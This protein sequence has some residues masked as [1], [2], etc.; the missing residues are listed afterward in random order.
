METRSC[1]VHGW[2]FPEEE[3]NG[4]C[5]KCGQKVTLGRN[6]K[7]SK[8]KKNVVD[9]DQL[10]S[11]YGADTARLFSLFAA[12]PEKDL[13]WN[14]QGVEG[15]Y[16]FL[17]RVWRAVYDNFDLVSGAS[18]SGDSD[19]R[20]KALR[21]QT[22]RTIKKVTE[23]IDGSFHFNTAISAVME[24]VNAI[25]AF[26]AKEQC[27]GVV[28]EALE[29][30]VLLLAPFVPHFSEELWL[31]LGHVGGVE[32]AGWPDF[33]PA[34]LVEEEK[35]IVVQVNGK[36]RGKVTVAANADEETLRAAA[37]AEDNVVR[38]IEGKTVRKVIVVPGRLVNVVVS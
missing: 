26:D 36:V 5:S 2:L 24:L 4:C 6:E 31:V 32:Q 34:A 11:R 30:V 1:P 8:S 12:P 38:F 22:H 10:I 14:E 20:G 21:R 23:D 9:P 29:A 15:C 37:L 17:N 16:R 18:L 3:I 25:Y 27:P 7:M 28:R 35:T 19:D 33:E 13:E